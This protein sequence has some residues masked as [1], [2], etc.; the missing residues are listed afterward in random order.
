MKNV[1]INDNVVDNDTNDFGFSFT[2]E[3]SF[4][5]VEKEAADKKI[6]ELYTMILSLLVNL[7]K[8]PDKD[9]IHWPGKDRIKSVDT[10][11]KKMDA[12]I[13]G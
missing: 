3:Q 4:T 10:F 6:T 1:T 12:L 5:K 8:N 13:D 2:D 11:I 9:I 7:K